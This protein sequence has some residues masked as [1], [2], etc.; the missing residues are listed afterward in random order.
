MA[1]PITIMMVKREGKLINSRPLDKIKTDTLLEQ[2]KDGDEVEVTYEVKHKD[3]S[4]AQ[5]SRLHASI[6]ALANETGATF[7]EMKLEVKRKAGLI[8][9]DKV[10]SF[11]AC[12]KEQLGKCIQVTIDIGDLLSVNLH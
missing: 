1:L 10:L 6:R 3:G 4:Y 9:G 2:L 11:A 12:S 5:K 7:E 8:V